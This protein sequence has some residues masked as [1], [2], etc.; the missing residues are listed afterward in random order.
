MLFFILR[1]CKAM[2]SKQLKILITFL[3]T[4]AL[5][6]ILLAACARPG[7]IASTTGGTP[8]AS[9]SSGSGSSGG[10][11]GCASGTAHMSASN[12]KQPCV[13]ISKGSKVTLADDV[14]VL[15]IITNGQW[16]NDNPQ[17]SLQP[18]APTINNVSISGGS[19]AIGPFNTAGKFNVL[20]TV[21]VGMNLVVNVT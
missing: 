16:A 8:T 12:F 5:G 15:H 21:H 7:T 3:A 6:S 13:N 20:C 11:S 10:G 9:S 14:Q 2:T 1:G 17:L 18:G 4:L 19:T